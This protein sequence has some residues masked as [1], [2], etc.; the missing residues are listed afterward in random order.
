MTKY[1]LGLIS[2]WLMCSCSDTDPGEAPPIDPPTPT[3][4]VTITKPE[5][6]FGF[7]GQSK[8]SYC[9]SALKQADGTVHLYFCGNPENLIM[10][11]NIFHIKIN[12]DG[13]QTAA[14]S[15]LQPGV[16]G[17]WDDHHTCDPSVIEGSFTWKNTTYK[18]AMFFL[19]NI[20]G[21]YYNEIGVAFSN[22]L[23]ADSWVK[24]PQQIVKKT[25]S[26]ESDQEIGGGGKSW[27]VGQPSVVSLDG[28][29]SYC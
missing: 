15:V 23:D 5:F 1:L 9:P 28:K 8:Y 26:S 27:G 6:V 16:S 24:Y 13:T 7:Q 20:Y 4:T 12:P 14:K 22:D 2:L 25:W 19:S 10:V 11:D 29:V 17:S 18:Y 21:V 3:P